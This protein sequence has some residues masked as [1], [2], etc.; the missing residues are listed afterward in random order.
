MRQRK[1]YVADERKQRYEDN[2]DPDL[3]HYYD[4]YLRP[5]SH[6]RNLR[7]YPY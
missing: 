5:H 3:D 2:Y 1:V 6:L 4:L 7:K